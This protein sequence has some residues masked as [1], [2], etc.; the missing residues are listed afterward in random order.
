MKYT[1]GLLFSLLLAF[2][3]SGQ[4]TS[5]YVALGLEFQQYPTGSIPGI[6]LGVSVAEHHSLDFRVGYNIVYHGDAGVRQLEEGGG[7]GISPGYQYWFR[8]EHEGLFLGARVDFWFNTIDWKDNIGLPNEV[9]GV[10]EITVVQP[11]IMGGYSIPIGQKLY[12]TP[13]L[14]VGAEINTQQ[15]GEDVGEGAILLA[16]IQFNYRI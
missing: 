4:S 1:I 16:G 5:N 9:N 10:T 13:T 8:S 14:A 3:A 11:T 2:S 12:L 15:E 7:F 6:R